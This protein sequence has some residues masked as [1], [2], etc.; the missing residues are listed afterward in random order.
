M[1]YAK[2]ADWLAVG[3]AVANG[4]SAANIQTVSFFMDKAKAVSGAAEKIAAFTFYGSNIYASYNTLF[5]NTVE[6]TVLFSLPVIAPFVPIS[7][8]AF[9]E[10]IYPAGDTVLKN[11]RLFTNRGLYNPWSVITV[12]GEKYLIIFSQSQ[13]WSIAVKAV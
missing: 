9:V 2:S 4:V 11:A 1:R 7:Q 10:D 3:F 13:H 12:N 6:N 8:D 5:G